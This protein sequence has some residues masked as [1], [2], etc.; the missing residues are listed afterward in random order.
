MNTTIALTISPKNRINEHRRYRNPAQS[1]YYDDKFFIQTVMDRSRIRD[2][3]IYPEFDDSGRLHY[4]GIVHVDA[5][6]KCRFYRY[7][8]AKLSMI[9]FVHF[10]VLHTEDDKERWN[11][12]CVKTW[13]ESKSILEIEYPM[14]YDSYR[15][16]TDKIQK[17]E[18]SELKTILDYF[19][20]I[21]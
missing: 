10:K 12:Y 13:D 1:V 9:G 3:K 18:N 21:Y 20:E 14:L 7:T 15:F 17:S 8:Q 19:D 5:N 11:K 4:H 2:Y 6:Q 16:I